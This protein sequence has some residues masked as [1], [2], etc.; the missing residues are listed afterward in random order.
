MVELKLV[1][2]Q[3]D[4]VSW[5]DVAVLC[6]TKVVLSTFGVKIKDVVGVGV[7]VLGGL[8]GARVV[9]MEIDIF[10]SKKKICSNR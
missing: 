3:D 4:V 8:F 2:I 7:V 9:G 1:C 5:D 10:I 6:F